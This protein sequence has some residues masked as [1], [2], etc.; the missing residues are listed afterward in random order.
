MSAHKV[1]ILD[2]LSEYT[3]LEATRTFR[4][5]IGASVFVSVVHVLCAALL[6]SA[7]NEWD[8]HAWMPARFWTALTEEGAFTTQSA[9][10][11]LVALLSCSFLPLLAGLAIRFGRADD[12]DEDDADARDSATI[13]G[14]AGGGLDAPLLSAD[15]LAGQGGAGNDGDRSADRSAQQ[16]SGFLPYTMFQKEGEKEEEDGRTESQLSQAMRKDE[17]DRRRAGLL[18]GGGP[19]GLTEAQAKECERLRQMQEH[20]RSLGQQKELQARQNGALVAL[21]FGSSALQIYCGV[22]CIGFRYTNEALHGSLMG[23][24]VMWINVLSWLLRELVTASGQV[25]G[26]LSAKVAELHPH[27]LRFTSK[28]ANHYCDVCGLRL[29]G[30][31]GYRC[32]LCDYDVCVRCFTRRDA[33]REGVL[34]GDKGVRVE[35]EISTMQYFRRALGLAWM[36]WPLLATA[37]VLL[38]ANN[39]T[40]LFTPHVQGAILDQVSQA[41]LAAFK[42][43]ISLYIGAMLLGGLLQGAQSLAFSI[44]GRRLAFIVRNQLFSGMVR[45]DV[46]FFDG[47]ASGQLTSRLSNDASFVIQ[48]V[49][50]LICLGSCTFRCLFVPVPA[51]PP[52]PSDLCGTARSIAQQPAPLCN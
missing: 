17:D 10:C 25:A 29:D 36:Q 47:N 5:L 33:A 9:D 51:T 7:T 40:R 20:E 6:Y 8:A 16:A 4:V 21:F 48:P 1:S 12:G 52:S 34:R 50:V 46:A 3:T 19:E 32:K 42:T 41:D 13:R 22:K 44:I 15:Q 49:Q 43:S 45:Q 28:C 24:A 38:V 39:A 27:T 35:S 11:V 18:R 14:R 26:A 30:G 23:L 31:K 37:L 2:A